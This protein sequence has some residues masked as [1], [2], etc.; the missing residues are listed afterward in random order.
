MNLTTKG[1]YAVMAM[2]DLAIH[3]GSAPVTLAQIAQRQNIA[4]NYLEQIFMKLRKNGLVN[5]VRGPGGGYVIPI[6][7]GS[8]KIADIV[9]AVDEAIKMTRC[10]DKKTDGCMHGK[11]KCITHNLWDGLGQQIF[12]YLNS[13]S[14]EDICKNNNPALANKHSGI[15]SFESKAAEA[16][17]AAQ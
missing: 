1:R 8:I 3:G 6:D 5:S 12:D 4:L 17:H 15:L 14:L 10:G 9:V 11:V 13:I 7:S 16:S 2:V